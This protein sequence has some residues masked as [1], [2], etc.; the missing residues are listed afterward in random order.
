MLYIIYAPNFKDKGFF[1][2]TLPK[3]WIQNE[4]FNANV[5]FIQ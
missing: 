5:F 1:F 4:F 3:I 2:H